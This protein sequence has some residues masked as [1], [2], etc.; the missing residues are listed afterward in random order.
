MITY[1]KNKTPPVSVVLCA[2]N[3]EKRIRKSLEAIRAANPDEIIVVDGNSSDETVSIAR[4]FTNNVIVSMAGSLTADRQVGIDACQH[5][6]IAMI[7]ADHRILPDTL[8]GLYA[9]LC[10][11][12]LDV[13]QADL[14]IENTGFW[15]AAENDAFDVFL[16][17]PGPKTMIGTAPAMYRRRVFKVNKFDA[18]ITRHKD[19]ADFFY[20]LSKQKGYRFGSGRT[21]VM[22]EHFASFGDYVKKFSWYGIGDAEFC[23]KHPSRAPSMFFHLFVRYPFIRSVMAIA[24]GKVRAVPYLVLCG[25]TRGSSMIWNLLFNREPK[26]LDSV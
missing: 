24:K 25:L 22:Q 13:V 11:F 1:L 23:V 18:H 8:T 17:K 10:E 16:N 9:D 5:D 6:L 15:A 26:T 3:E 12:D 4:E 20:R 14:G 7:D 2:R 19:D 21:R